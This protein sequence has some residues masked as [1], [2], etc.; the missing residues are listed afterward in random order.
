M[1]PHTN[2]MGLEVKMLVIFFILSFFVVVI[3]AYSRFVILK[4]FTF[5]VEVPCNPETQTCFVRDCEVDYCPPNNLTEYA[6]FNIRG[7]QYSSC[8]TGTCVL[9]CS[10]ASSQ[11]EAVSCDPENGDVCT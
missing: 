4:D 7:Y 8:T 11:C 1:K 6:L 5:Q 9:Y 3:S 10:R 2:S